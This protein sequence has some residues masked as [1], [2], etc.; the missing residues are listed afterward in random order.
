MKTACEAVVL[1]KTQPP[2]IA[3]DVRHLRTAR[4]AG[5]F[6]SSRKSIGATSEN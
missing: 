1:K 5:Q 2:R 6:V 3:R 4:C